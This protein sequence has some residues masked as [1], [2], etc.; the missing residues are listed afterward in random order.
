MTWQKWIF[1]FLIK[2]LFWLPALAFA[3]D[4]P[5]DDLDLD[6]QRSI[7]VRAEHAFKKHDYANFD[8]LSQKITTY[9]LYPYLIYEELKR[10]IHTGTSS[11]TYDKIQTFK[12]A[13]PDFPYLNALNTLWLTKLAHSKKWEQY[14]KDYEPSKNED[15]QCYYHY[16][17]YEVTKEEKHLEN[18]KALWLVGYPQGKGCDKLFSAW[19]KT[20]GL[21]QSL[22]WKRFKLS[23]DQKNEDLSKHLLKKMNK[24][25]KHAANQWLKLV[26]D[27]HLV[28]S[29]KFQASFNAP[30]KIKAD[31]MTY[32]LQRLSRKD[33]VKVLRWWQKNQ[34]HN[35]FTKVQQSMIERDIGVY[36][37]H[38]KN[39]EAKTYLAS[40]NDKSLDSVA[41]E[42]RIRLALAEKNWNEVLSLI[43]Q[44]PPELKDDKNWRYWYARALE[45][46]NQSEQALPIYQQLASTRNYYGFL[47]SLRLGQTI[48]IA[49]RESP[50]EKGTLVYVNNLPA[51]KRFKELNKLGK[52]A[53]GRVEWFRALDKMQEDEIIASAKIAQQMGFHDIAIFTMARAEF[54]DDVP[55]RFPLAHKQEIIE[56]AD[57]H[58][59]DPAWIYGIA[60][61]ESAFFNEAVSHAGARG[62]LQLLPS[63]AK[64]LAKE[65][66][67]PYDSEYS[68][69][70]PNTNIQLGTAYL[71]QLKQMMRNHLVL[72]TASYNAGPTRTLRWLPKEPQDA[73]IWIETVPYKE[74]R[75]YVKNVL[76][77]TSIYRQRLGYPPAFALLMK[78]IPQKSS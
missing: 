70:K 30:D 52:E 41:K 69:H 75:E 16:A 25:E 51:I 67:V 40:L 18:A 28:L 62:L 3:N 57:K 32:G 61:Q 60:R 6:A 72:A 44:L 14:L 17:Q 23:I 1:V 11:A 65:N 45:K 15:L 13:F 78:P 73:D 56:N 48:S 38:Q 7:Y 2:A 36:L 43:N 58:N 71:H 74:T 50:I 22:I 27:P 63:T 76:T 77:F 20:G 64:T 9:P 55:L 37:C 39:K 68:L 24:Q 10:K 47:S 5:P 4:L 12:K 42:W 26:K 35:T 33:P 59:I 29:E 46:T 8:K 54:K 31:I 21:T 53:V 49:H 19:A 34:P 66:H